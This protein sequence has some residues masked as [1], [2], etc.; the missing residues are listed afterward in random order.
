M[1][2]FKK[3]YDIKNLIIKK[4]NY[5]SKKIYFKIPLDQ[6]AAENV[7]RN[8]NL[9]AFI[10]TGPRLNCDEN[11]DLEKMDKKL[12]EEDSSNKDDK[13]YRILPDV[14]PPDCKPP[15]CQKLLDISGEP[16][17]DNNPTK[18]E[19]DILYYDYTIKS[20]GDEEDIDILIS[21]I[22]EEI[23]EIQKNIEKRHGNINE[24]LTQFETN[25]TFMA[26]YAEIKTLTVKLEKKIKDHTRIIDEVS[27]IELLKDK[28]III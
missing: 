18:Y 9:T 11:D 2:L 16:F 26:C 7:S 21:D 28:N 25:A 27:K 15:N 6:N 23:N 13:G 14:N 1:K 4:I 5:N 22:T 19:N 10:K 17:I 12:F 3:K 8:L 20:Y 24:K